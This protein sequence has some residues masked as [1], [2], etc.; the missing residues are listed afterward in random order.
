MPTIYDL[1]RHLGLGVSTISKALNGYS[2]VSE[3]TRQRVLEAAREMGF[4]PNSN[5]QALKTKRSRLIGVLHQDIQGGGLM[6]PHF[7]TILEYFRRSVEEH[8]YELMLMNQNT[9][10]RR[11]NFVEQCRYRNFEGILIMVAEK[12]DP[13]VQQLIASEV[14]KVLV[15]AEC[16]G[17]CSVLSDNIQGGIQAVEYLYS[18]GHRRIA[19]LAAPLETLAGNERMSGYREGLARVGLKFE[20]ELV[21]EAPGFR[22][23]D[24]FAAM[25]ALLRRSGAFSAVFAGSD[26][27]AFGAMDALRQ[28]G[29]HVPEQISMVGFDNLDSNMMSLWPLTTIAQD[30]ERIGRTAADLLFRQITGQDIETR[31]LRLPVQLVE[32]TT[33][34]ELKHNY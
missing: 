17:Q 26:S 25:G 33:C 21:T 4:Q 15:D 16:P 13:D 7:G 19:H 29:I 31:Q 24:G 8:G 6:H 23:S 10:R 20:P 2:D 27:L 3:K 5:A 11:R 30:R 12:N 14:P 22:V 9:G 34:I 32:R 28:R 18:R 1:S